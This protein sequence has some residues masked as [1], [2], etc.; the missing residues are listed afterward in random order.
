MMFVVL[1]LAFEIARSI[2]LGEHVP[3]GN[4]IRESSLEG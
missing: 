2:Y 4:W 3:S 1:F